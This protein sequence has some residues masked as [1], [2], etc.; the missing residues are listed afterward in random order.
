MARGRLGACAIVLLCSLLAVNALIHKLDIVDDPRTAFSIEDF[1]YEVGGQMHMTVNNMKMTLAGSVPPADRDPDHVF[2]VG[3]LVKRMDIDSSIFLEQVAASGQTCP[4][5]ASKLLS[6]EDHL[7][8]LPYRANWTHHEFSMT[9]GPGLAGQYHILFANCVPQTK[10]TSFQLELTQVN[11]GPSY[12]SA[13]LA[14]LPTLFGVASGIYMLLICIWSWVTWH[15]R[16]TVNR[17]HHLMT[18]L[19][20][21]KMISVLAESIRLQFIK[22]TGQPSGWNI[23]Y[24]VFY[25]L[26]AISMFVVI[27]LIGSGWSFVK[28]YLSARD[29]KIIALVI[30]LQVLS[31]IAVIVID[32]IAPGSQEYRS[33]QSVLRIVDVI[34]CAAVLFP[35]IWSVRH[36]REASESDGKAAVN[37]QKLTLF[38]HFYVMVVVYVYFTRII[39]YLFD[40]TLT[41]RFAWTRDFLLEAAT[42]ILWVITGIKFSPAPD[43]PYFAIPQ[44][45]DE[46]MGELGAESPPSSDR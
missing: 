16:N 9:V 18:I 19:L 37:L 42:L 28:P 7:V 34:C 41:F 32:V 30:P 24:Y 12:L 22:D 26:Q 21:V 8:L 40:S 43:N 6:A 27:L 3:F 46:E 38:R 25:T 36:L 45:D 14:P 35:I 20:V 39:I 17:V 23:V 2:Q 29:T 13:G 31:N 5:T 10:T 33:W 1:G 15:H 44:R 11:P 4:L